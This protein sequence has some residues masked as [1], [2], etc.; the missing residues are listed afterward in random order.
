MN[1]DS[2]D[3]SCPQ[4]GSGDFGVA[5]S[6]GEYV[7]ETC[8]TRYRPLPSVGMAIVLLLVGIPMLAV[9]VW[10]GIS[11]FRGLEGFNIG[12]AVVIGLAGAVVVRR[13]IIDL[14]R[15][16]AG[17]PRGFPVMPASTRNS[18][19]AVTNPKDPPVG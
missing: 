9:A 7:C 8:G 1:F 6:G 4:C 17:A 16:N 19:D 5:G 10:V 13:A 15:S 18:R 3:D 12:L 11:S 2:P 14:Q